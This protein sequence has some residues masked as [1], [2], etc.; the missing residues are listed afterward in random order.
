LKAERINVA[1][2]ATTAG[3][4]ITSQVKQ[5]VSNLDLR[6]HHFFDE[7]SKVKVAMPKRTTRALMPSMLSI[8]QRWILCQKADF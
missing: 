2:R 1:I 6:S 8:A 4:E 7:N 3:G 5:G